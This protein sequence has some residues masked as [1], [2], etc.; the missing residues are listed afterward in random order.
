MA[1]ITCRSGVKL[2]PA[3]KDH[4]VRRTITSEVKQ[5]LYEKHNRR[6]QRRLEGKWTS[7]D[8]DEFIREIKGEE[9]QAEPRHNQSE[10]GGGKGL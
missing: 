7:E 2:L 4:A 1:F 8:Q 6:Y 10:D 5:H 3:E 9:G